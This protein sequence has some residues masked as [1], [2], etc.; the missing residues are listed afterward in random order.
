MLAIR[1]QRTGRRGHTQFR[2]I[3]QDA[4]SHPKSGR[5]VAYLGSYD[6]HTKQALLKTEQINTYVSNGAQPTPRVVSIL[7]K[8][9]FKLPKWVTIPT[10]KKSTTKNVEKLR[11]NRPAG[12][13]APAK[14]TPAPDA[15]EAPAEEKTEQTVDDASAAAESTTTEVA[16][17]TEAASEPEPKQTDEKPVVPSE[18][19][20]AELQPESETPKEA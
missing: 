3:V 14:E 7:K 13:P 11:R 12:E 19:V 8:E 15:G 2:V 17:P 10:K 4:R 6:P 1:M 9:G 18:P 20:S 16:P 5:I